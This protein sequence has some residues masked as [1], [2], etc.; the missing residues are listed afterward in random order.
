MSVM[1]CNRRGCENIM[2]DRSS[3]EHGYICD[4]CF[5]ELLMRGVHTPVLTFMNLEKQT[6]NKEATEVYF[7]TIFP[8]TNH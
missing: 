4:E 5:Q 1:G 3:D 8:K 6:S 7:N 2:C